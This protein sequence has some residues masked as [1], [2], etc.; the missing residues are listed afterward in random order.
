MRK[1][2]RGRRSDEDD[3]PVEAWARGKIY[4]WLLAL[5]LVVFVLGGAFLGIGVGG[6]NA[7]W[8]QWPM[9]GCFHLVLLAVWLPFFLL[10]R[11]RGRVI[12][13]DAALWVVGPLLAYAAGFATGYFTSGPPGVG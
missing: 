2:N 3:G 13:L 11:R 6:R 8:D 12:G 10:A 9:W 5:V 1:L 7:R 4:Q